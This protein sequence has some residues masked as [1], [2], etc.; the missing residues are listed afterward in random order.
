V[1]A[2]S[3]EDAL[4]AIGLDCVVEE[5]ERLALLMPRTTETLVQV[6]ALRARAVELAR[7]YGFTNLALEIPACTGAD[8]PVPRR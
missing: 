1:N 5:R 8:A 6:G 4:R 3:L 2:S 7:A